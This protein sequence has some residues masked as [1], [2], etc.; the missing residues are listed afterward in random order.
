MYFVYE[1]EKW[2]VICIQYGGSQPITH[3]SSQFIYHV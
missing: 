1:A 3:I 2:E